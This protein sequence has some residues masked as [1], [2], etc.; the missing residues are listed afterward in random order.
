MKSVWIKKTVTVALASIAFVGALSI[1]AFAY[2]SP[3]L[4]GEAETEE[5]LFVSEETI[6][7]NGWYLNPQDYKWYFLKD[8]SYVTGWLKREDKWFYMD[9]KGG[10]VNDTTLLID[11]S[12]YVFSKEG[13]CTNKQ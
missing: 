5:A 3:G 2:K 8:G 1:S 4:F 10:M 12:V 6:P 7:T 9:E 11:G 13:V